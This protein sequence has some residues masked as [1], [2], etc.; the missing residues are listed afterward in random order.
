MWCSECSSRSKGACGFIGKRLLWRKDDSF[1]I[2]KAKLRGV[3]SAG[4]ICA[5]DELGLGDDHD[6]IMILEDL[7]TIGTPFKRSWLEG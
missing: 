1:V 6:G 3:E 5:E 4:M 7:I 2:K